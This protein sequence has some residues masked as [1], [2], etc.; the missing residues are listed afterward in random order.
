MC[1]IA[2]IIDKNSQSVNTDIIC[3]RD[4]MHRGGPDHAGI[5]TDDTFKLALG[6]RR[7]SIIDL[8]DSANQPMFDENK[9]IVLIFNG[10]IY[11]YP[12]LKEELFACG[13]RF[14]TQSDSEVV[15]KAY[16]KWGTNC[17]SRFRGMFSIALYDK[18][19]GK[20]ILARDHAGIKPLYYYCDNHCLYFASEVKAFK[21]L[22]KWEENPNWKIYFLTFGYLP[23]SITTLKNIKQLEKG[24]FCIIDVQTLSLQKFYFTKDHFS[25]EVKNLEEARELIK[26]ALHKSVQRHLIADAPLGLFLSGGIDS[27]LLTLLAKSFKQDL[28]TLSIVFN[29]EN[30]SEKKYQRLVAEKVQSHHKEFL[31]NKQIF[32]DALPDIMRAMDQPSADG[33]NSYFISAFAKE[34]GLKAVLSGLGADELFGGYPSF[35]RMSFLKNLKAL[36]NFVLNSAKLSSKDKYRKIIFLKNKNV[37]GDY[38]FNRGFFTPADVARQLN[39]DEK[40]VTSLLNDVMI[41]SFVNQLSEGNKVSYFETNLYMENQLLKD[42]DFMSMWHGLEVRVPFLDY[43]LMTTV[44]KIHCSL[45][46]NH[47]QTKFLLIDSFKE[48]LPEEIWQRKKQGF[49]FPFDG[50]M[51]ENAEQFM[52]ANKN[53]TL[54]KKFKSGKLSWSRYWTYLVSQTFEP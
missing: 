41:P 6:H 19:N 38:L 54:T 37:L 8:C 15:I 36:P 39:I 17:F 42:T 27:S 47:P 52:P 14:T 24:S 45:K 50:W 18:Q 40:Q 46:F 34:A 30:Y 26:T 48:L 11:N 21:Q 43:D 2:G 3:M 32:I 9:Q 16:Q 25:E 44:Q 13:F 29:E 4:A 33:V 31:L 28:H 1:R 53:E 12:D 22:K 5:Y 35:K 49:V 20:L 10:E 51:K 23:N 7:L